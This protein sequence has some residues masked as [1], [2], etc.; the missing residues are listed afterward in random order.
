MTTTKAREIRIAFSEPYL[1]S[2]LV[3]VM[4]AED[5]QKYNS[6]DSVLN[7]YSTVGAV[8][9]TTGDAF[10]KRNFPNA[11]RKTFLP[12]P[13]DGVNELKRRAID[14]FLHDAPSVVWF[15]SEN[16]AD[17]TA[18]WEP[19]TDEH[20]A[21]GVRKTDQKL[22]TDINS[23]LNKWKQDGTLDGILTNWLPAEYLKRI[24]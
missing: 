7:S 18:L 14:I 16:E 19:L 3:A 20:L 12:N 23:V 15:V 8:K 2:G 9:G 22:L 6:P 5:S 21:W 10:L 24:H 13:K 17:I 11:V 4:R 1:R